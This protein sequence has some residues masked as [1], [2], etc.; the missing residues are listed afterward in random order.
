MRKYLMLAVLIGVQTVR[1]ADIPTLHQTW[2]DSRD[3]NSGWLYL[4]KNEP[5]IP[6]DPDSAWQ[7]V[8]LPHTWNARDTLSGK[9]YRRDISWYRRHIGLAAADLTQRQFIRFGAAGQ[10]A[11]VFVNGKPVGEHVGGYSAFTVEMTKFLHDGDNVVDV[12]VDNMPDKTLPPVGDGL[13]NCYGGLYRS[14]QWLASPAIC[15]GRAYRGG[16]GIRVWS[17][18]VSAESANL[19]VVAQVDNGG[20]ESS[21]ITIE[22]ELADSK[23]KVVATMKSLGVAIAAGSIRPVSLVF[24]NIPSPALWSPEAPNLYTVTVRLVC[25]GKELDRATVRHGFRWFQFTADHGFFLNGQPYKLHGVNRHQDFRGEGNALTLQRHYDDIRMMKELGVNW[26][27]LAH[28]QQNDYV[29][30]LCDELG[31]MV[32]EEIPFVRDAPTTPQFEKNAQSMLGEMIEQHFNSPSVLLWGMGNE[33]WLGK[34]K[35]G[36]AVQ[37]EMISRLNDT[38]HRED[39]VRKSVIVCGDANYYS[40]LKIMTIPD[41]MGYNLYYGWY[42]GSVDKFTARAIQLHQMD[43]S[44]PMIIS[45]FGAGCDPTVHREKPKS[46]DQSQEY[47]VFFLEAHLKQMDALPWLSGC[48]WWNF[49]D[50]GWMKSS[51]PPLF[52]NK[53]LVTFDRQ[54]KDSFYCLKAHWSK[55]PVLYLC[56]PSWTERDGLPVKQYRVMTNLPEV[57][58]FQNGNSLGKKTAEFV[59][60]V[61][62]TPGPNKLSAVGS[63]Q[64]EQREH[65][66]TVNYKHTA[67]RGAEVKATLPTGDAANPFK[68]K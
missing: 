53:G 4:E 55:E 12:R 67:V 39:P 49:A 24:T 38:I 2:R 3:L 46:F 68:T 35:D 16:S 30:Q 11:A 22:S 29:L 34:G 9:T 17:D 6:A 5:N 40:N 64:G 1:A 7:K 51:N 65:G 43:P 37:F 8:E 52:N 15:L 42:G 57:E 54:K 14:V 62:L 27:R 32:W 45:E 21:T 36:R 48:N 19:N 50:F 44:K 20:V 61:T 25:G 28:Y 13:F 47:Q 56:S 60:D 26:L 23:G 58:L 31:I 33:I 66:F 41:V 10:K 18:K 63:Y 59:W